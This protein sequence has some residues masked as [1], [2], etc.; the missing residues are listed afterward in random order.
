LDLLTCS[1]IV[2]DFGVASRLCTNLAKCS[3]H[4]I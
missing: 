1:A 3:I 4:P 2:E